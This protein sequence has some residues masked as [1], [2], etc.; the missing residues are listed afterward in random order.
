MKVV[1]SRVQ[2]DQGG[3]Q[4]T[5]PRAARSPAVG[6]ECWDRRSRPGGPAGPQRPRAEHPGRRAARARREATL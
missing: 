5:H 3:L 6:G 2:R 4:R 1:A